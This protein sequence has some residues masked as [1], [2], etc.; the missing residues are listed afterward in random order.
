MPRLDIKTDFD[1]DHP[2]GSAW[3]ELNIGVAGQPGSNIFAIQVGT[4]EAVLESRRAAES[5][6]IGSMVLVREWSWPEIERAVRDIVA[7]CDTGEWRMS[8]D[9][10]ERHFHH[11]YQDYDEVPQRL[12]V[13]PMIKAWRA[14]VHL[15][16][17]E[18]LDGE[19]V[20]LEIELTVGVRKQPDD[21]EYVV[22]VA[23]PEGL[24]ANR[25]S[26]LLADHAVLL[27]SE[28]RWDAIEEELEAIVS[29][30]R[31]NDWAHCRRKLDRFFERRKRP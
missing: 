9:E 28:Y 27:I 5:S 23:T 7:R 1:I 18:P 15:Q 22:T 12:P 19:P 3:I 26:F 30:C 17:W 14:G 10:L 16:T 25:S 8:V 11:E 13:V 4:P 21:R 31:G 29:R 20:Y 24:R 6:A 2:G